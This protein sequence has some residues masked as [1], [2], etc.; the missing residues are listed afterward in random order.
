MR[1]R[2]ADKEM[3]AID[4]ISYYYDKIKATEDDTR[5]T[6]YR[7]LLD[8]VVKDYDGYA[9]QLTT[10]D[11]PSYIEDAAY[12]EATVDEELEELERLSDGAYARSAETA[13][14][15]EAKQA[16]GPDQKAGIADSPTMDMENMTVEELDEQIAKMKKLLELA[17]LHKQVKKHE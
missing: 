9:E 14:P 8:C 1:V 12:T 17:E 4:F 7:R 6:P 3:W 13:G 5:T 10:Y 2:Q 11:D 16:A 15:G